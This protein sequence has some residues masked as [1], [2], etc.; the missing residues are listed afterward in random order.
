MSSNP[1][2]RSR[3]VKHEDIAECPFILTPSTI[4]KP[5][6]KRDDKRKKRKR[7][8]DEDATAEDKSKLVQASPF[9]LP[10]K[11]GVPLNQAYAIEP[12]G[13]WKAMT[14]YNSFVCECS[15]D[16]LS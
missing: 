3:T 4:D 10:G 5:V 9:K 2:R 13:R 11:I 1:R 14:R 16:A 7:G 8:D 12:L 6:D 15:P